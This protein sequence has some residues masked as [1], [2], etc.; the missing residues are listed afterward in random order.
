MK[1]PRRSRRPSLR[2]RSN[3]ACTHGSRCANNSATAVVGPWPWNQPSPVSSSEPA[4]RSRCS[5]ASRAFFS[6][7][8]AAARTFF[9]A[10]F[11]SDNDPS[12]ARPNSPASA[13]GS[14]TA[15]EVT[16]WACAAD[17]SPSR[18]AASVAGSR[19]SASAVAMSRPASRVD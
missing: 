1:A 11:N 13:E 5:W 19:P 15:A 12:R 6:L 14:S 10:R 7:S 3:S 8:V 4:A 2:A 17:S 9:A 16:S 18:S